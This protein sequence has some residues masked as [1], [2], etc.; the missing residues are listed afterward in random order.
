MRRASPGDLPFISQLVPRLADPDFCPEYY[1]TEQL[2]SGTIRALRSALERSSD[3]ELFVVA[4]DAGREVGFLWAN[5]KH[6]YFTAEAHGYIEE[7]AVVDDAQ[8]TGTRL[9]EF[10]EDWSR[11]RGHRYISLSVRP[12]N[13]RARKLYER[14]GYA[15]DVEVRLKLL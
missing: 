11:E 7:V 2:V 15:L 5:T 3:D 13:G 14:R 6:D 9:L 12:G 1:D 10:A 4:S 8:G